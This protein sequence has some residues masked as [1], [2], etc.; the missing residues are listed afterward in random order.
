MPI[1]GTRKAWASALAA[2]NPTRMPVNNPGP[3]SAATSPNS[4][5]LIPAC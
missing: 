4:V 5:T 2:A 1:I 3:M